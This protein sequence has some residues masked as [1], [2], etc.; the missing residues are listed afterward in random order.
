[1]V[2][3][4][5]LSPGS[6]ARFSLSILTFVSVL[7]Y[8]KLRR[9]SLPLPP[10][11]K[12]LPLVGN[13][14]SM[15]T[16]FEWETF[17][18]WSKE[19]CS[20]IIHLRV[21]GT[22]IIVISS[23]E[24]AQ[25]LLSER[26]AIYS[27]RPRSTMLNEMVGGDFLFPF[28]SNG[29]T[30]RRHRRLFHGEFQALAARR[31]RAQERKNAHKLVQNLLRQPDSFNQQFKHAVSANILSIAYGIDCAPFDDPYIKIGENA[32]AAMRLA[33]VPGKFLVDI[34]PALKHV[35]SWLPG[36]G[37]KRKAIAW[38]A[39]VDSMVDE[40]FLA[41]KRAVESGMAR[42]SFVTNSLSSMD[43]Q[44]DQITQEIDLKQ[45]AGSMYAG[46]DTSRTAL[47]F[48]IKAMM[49]N[50]TAQKAAQ[51]EIDTVLRR[52][53]LPDF[54][55][56]E[57][58]PYTIAIVKE[59]LRWRPN[60]PIGIP[61][62]LKVEDEYRGYRIPAG[63]V[64]I[65]NIWAMVHD[66]AVYP[67]PDMFKPERFLRDGKLNTDSTN[68]DPWWGFGRRSCPGKFVAEDMIWIIVVSIL[69][70][71]EI[72]K[73]VGET[74]EYLDPGNTSDLGIAPL[75]FMCSITPRKNA[76]ADMIRDECDFT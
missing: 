73:P 20:D 6:Y 21:L 19:Y 51:V 7:V 9:S 30:W 46:S 71:F 64:I 74:G 62:Y 14:F 27:D 15:P 42:P 10:G 26:S 72:S 52:G 57:D 67:N 16:Q 49:E 53:H 28:M 22:S 47:L 29:E 38:K 69:A 50:P 44:S 32:I 4:N 45:V 63:S 59:L 40:P 11:P 1:M 56:Q 37:F 66:E 60:A 3:V 41:A 36:A 68:V 61:H 33:A 54:D 12:K 34:L 8:F 39:M 23:A 17:M 25:E 76:A 43:E 5:A 75:P 65:A 48:F 24:T 18:Q 70:V 58:M 13:L 2:D 31:F 35:P 55:D